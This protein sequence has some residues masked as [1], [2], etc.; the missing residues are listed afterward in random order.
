MPISHKQIKNR[1]LQLHVSNE[2]RVFVI[3]DLHGEYTKLMALLDEIQF[4]DSDILIA[5]GDLI[6][7]GTDSLKCL[8]IFCTHDN[9]LT[10]IGNHE[11]MAIKS[12]ESYDY[13][14]WQYN[15]GDWF[16]DLAD[17]LQLKAIEYLNHIY[18]RGHYAI[19]LI[20][21]GQSTVIVHA[22]IPN[23]HYKFG[24]EWG[25][26]DLHT[27]VWSRA[28]IHDLNSGLNVI[29]T[30]ADRFIFGH[31]PQKRIMTYDNLIYL[32]TGACYKGYGKL[33]FIE[34]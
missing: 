10:V 1:H 31:T 2:T 13:L 4:T 24:E 7:R 21:N 27:L 8:E 11:V 22:D 17:E 6:D 34:I 14:L 20:K 28:T 29:I 3:G 26:Q 19:N 18:Y 23:H 33:S 12:I 5:T 16:F 25:E 15:G 9:F 32:D 30:G